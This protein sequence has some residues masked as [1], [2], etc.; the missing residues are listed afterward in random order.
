MS[1]DELFKLWKQYQHSDD[2]GGGE[3]NFT[4]FMWWLEKRYWSRQS[5]HTQTKSTKDKE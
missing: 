5:N 4:G 1:A 2:F 3:D